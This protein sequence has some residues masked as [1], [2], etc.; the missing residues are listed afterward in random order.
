MEPSVPV[1]N[2]PEFT[3]DPLKALL[4]FSCYHTMSGTLFSREAAL[5]IGG[6]ETSVHLLDDWDFFVRLAK[7]FSVTKVDKPLVEYRVHQHQYSDT[8]FE[9]YE[10]YLLHE[11][12][13]RHHRTAQDYGR[14]FVH[15]QAAQLQWDVARKAL[16]HGLYKEFIQRLGMVVSHLP[17]TVLNPSSYRIVINKFR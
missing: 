1:P 11:F 13:S 14:K 8:E 16:D 17:S 9:N 5:E 4:L 10:F 2:P 3:A 6:L 7:R 15:K 12:R